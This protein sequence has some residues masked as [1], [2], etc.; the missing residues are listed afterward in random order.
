MRHRLIGALAVVGTLLIPLGAAV[1]ADATVALPIRIDANGPGLTDSSG[2]LW[3][4]D[5]GYDI[6]Y[7]GGRIPSPIE[8][9]VDDAL[10]QTYNAFGGGAGYALDLP[11]GTY[12]VTL[13]MVEDWATAAGQRRFDVRAEGVTA[14]GAFDIYANCG[15]LTACDRSFTVAVTDGRLNLQFSANGGANHATVSA[16]EITAATATPSP[17]PTTSPSP[18]A[19]PT[20]SPTVSP[21]GSPTPSPGGGRVVAVSTASG[22]KTALSTALPGD[23]IRLAD[24]RYTGN[25]KA[26]VAAR[27][28]ARITI[29]GSSGAVLTAGGGYGLHLNGAS[30]WTVTGVTITGGQKGIMI[31]AAK[32]VVIDGVTVHDLDMEGVH[33]R[34]SSTDGV[35]RNSTIYDTGNDGRGMGEGV[36][37]GTANTL[38]DNSDRI[39]IA[40]NTIGPDVGGENVDIKEGTTGARIVGNTFDGGGLTGANYDDSW[41]DVK[42]NDVLVQGNVG[43]NTT[44]NGYETHTQRPGWG[45]GTVFRDNVSDLTGATGDRRLAIN[46]TNHAPGC[47]TTVHASNTVTG[48]NGLTNVPVTP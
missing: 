16:V 23:T 28:D 44:N 43:R 47:E 46:V 7:G 14:L 20:A 5:R 21:T 6:R 40:G 30:Y 29:T 41:V 15:R 36:Y 9:T 35:I 38:S 24:G 25:F 42:G 12:R 3:E 11:N 13:K 27:P 18:T 33:F 32:G 8:G 37:V 26:T 19:S 17:S 4:A 31:D 39:E 2:N 22:L 1:Q 34:N 45:C 48:G 10:Y